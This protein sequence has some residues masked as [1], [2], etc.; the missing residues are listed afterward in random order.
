MNNRHIGIAT[1][2]TGFNYG[3]CLQAYALK[4]TLNQMG[5]TPEIYRLAGSRITD[6]DARM[7]KIFIMRVRAFLHQ[8][9]KAKP[10]RKN[11]DRSEGTKKL[12][13]AFYVQVLQPETVRWNEL[14]R[15]ARLPFYTGF[16]CGSD[17]IWNANALY[18]DPLYYLRF[19]PEEKRIAIAAS[20]GASEIPSYN[21]RIMA[22]WIR[23]IPHL[24]VREESGRKLVRDLTGKEAAVIADPVFL[25]DKDAWIEA[26]SLTPHP[27]RYCLA[28]FLNTPDEKAEA[29]LKQAEEKGFE[30]IRLPYA[31][32]EEKGT[33]M[34]A[35]PI[36][37]LNLLSGAEAVLTDSFHALSFSILFHRQV[38]VFRKPGASDSQHPM[39]LLNLL[40]VFDMESCFER[41]S[42]EFLSVDWEEKDRIS[43]QEREKIMDYLLCSLK[44]TEASFR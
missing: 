9:H 7:D 38:F 22:K 19:A 17:Q 30:I 31:D 44:E 24:S 25:L 28:Y 8:K 21:R 26:L 13:H 27:G 23:E 6:R 37:F 43:R 5:Y 1:L 33:A 32:D 20:F 10:R 35:G 34:D 16:L 4:Y 42:L 3:S 39:R 41:E 12:F 36:E 14:R 11:H 29:L 2:S 15:R 18:I 40:K